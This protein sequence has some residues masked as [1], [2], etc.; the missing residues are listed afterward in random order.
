[1][2]V[3]GATLLFEV[4]ARV[5][6]AEAVAASTVTAAKDKI[7]YFIVINLCEEIGDNLFVI[8]DANI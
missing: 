7:W 2:L 5:V 3:E 8:L 6:A 1:V 4:I